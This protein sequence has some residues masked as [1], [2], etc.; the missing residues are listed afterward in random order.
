MEANSAAAKSTSGISRRRL[1]GYA[2]CAGPGAVGLSRRCFAADAGAIDVHHHVSPPVW[3]QGAREQIAAT[4]RNSA[5]ITGW[6]AA[7]SLDEMDR[8]GVTTSVASVTNPGIWFG[9]IDAARKLARGCNE[10]MA[11]LK[12]DAPGRFAALAAIPLPD[13]PGALAEIEYALDALKLDGVGLLSN[14]DS[15]WL[16]DAAFA[17]VLAEFDRRGATVFVHPTSSACCS[18][19]IPDVSFSAIEFP[20]DTT[21]AIVSLLF[22]GALNKYPDIKWIFSHAGGAMPMLAQR[23]AQIMEAQPALK[24]R[25]PNGVLH[26]LKRLHYD[27]ALA[28][29][30]MA[31]AALTGLAPASQILFGTD[32]PLS[33]PKTVLDNVVA[34]GFDAATLGAIRRDNALRLFPRISG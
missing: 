22:S 3:L 14:Y 9:D 8:A 31:I 4:N 6:S 21:R 17:P 15:K 27:L 12:Q 34:H 2:C 25:I 11:R 24:P 28:A 33:V 23:V 32:Y 18:A 7:K 30:P 29:N 20:I 19:Q 10:F 13:A 1:L 5:A 16:G 26:E